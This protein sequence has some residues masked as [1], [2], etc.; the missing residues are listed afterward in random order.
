MKILAID[1]SLAA[2]A[3]C[4]WD[5]ENEQ[6]DFEET[7]PMARGHAEALM[8]LVMRAAAKAPTGLK[9][10]ERIAVTVGPGSF[11][12]LRI[13]ISAARALAQVL[14]IPVVGVSALSALAAPEVLANREVDIVPV[15]DARH[16]NVFF[17]MISGAGKTLAPA[18]KASIAEVAG[19]LTGR[20]VRVL[21]NIED[22]AVSLLA[23][24]ASAK[25]QFQRVTVPDIVSVARLGAIADPAFAPARPLYLSA[26]DAKP[27]VE[28]STIWTAAA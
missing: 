4:I 13:G 14:K 7:Q 9:G 2:T 20:T 6:I 16:G 21:G 5:N 26:A 1:T 24:R 22:D 25:V 15:I 19:Q 23:Q 18:R 17:Q 10:V 11:T 8:P 3:C 28:R 27:S 12:G